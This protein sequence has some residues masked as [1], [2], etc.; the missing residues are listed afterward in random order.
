MT[1]PPSA[2]SNR[3]VHATYQD[4]I[5]LNVNNMKKHPLM[6]PLDLLGPLKIQ[7]TPLQNDLAS[8][9]EFTSMIQKLN[10][11]LYIARRIQDSDLTFVLSRL[12]DDNLAIWWKL[13]GKH[14]GRFS[15]V[16]KE[17]WNNEWNDK[18][19]DF[20][21]DGIEGGACAFRHTLEMY[22]SSLGKTSRP[23]IWISY[24]LV[25]TNIDPSTIH[26]DLFPYVEMVMTALT[27]RDVP[28]VV[29]LG[30][31]R[32]RHNTKRFYEGHLSQHK[33]LSILLQAFT[34]KA[35]LNT[36]QG[37]DKLWMRTRPTWPMV[38][39]LDK[40]LPKN[41][42]L[43]ESQN[44]P[45]ICNEDGSWTIKNLEG[46]IIYTLTKEEVASGKTEFCRHP[47]MLQPLPD[48]AVEYRSLANLF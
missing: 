11:N 37:V 2:T 42:F 19:K 7:N 43:K 22:E 34:A 32:T 6:D 18:Q 12:T 3:P 4:E 1:S 14:A 5:P 40:S 36:V 33:E 29:H 25:G 47:E 27:H 20:F 23:E 35:I 16:L 39:I 31:G 46:K 10:D 24:V 9:V 8:K 28:I 17:L 45:I 15:E 44:M 21:I 13:H 38:R 30:I 41:I 48:Y 26:E